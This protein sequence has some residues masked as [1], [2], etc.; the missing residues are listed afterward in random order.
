M[1]PNDL[2]EPSGLTLAGFA[3]PVFDSTAVFRTALAAF[4]APATVLPMPAFSET[5]AGLNR[6]ATAVLLTLLDMDTKLWLSDE[7]DRAQVR[8]Y[9][10]FHTG[11]RFAD[12][13]GQCDF[14][15]CSAAEAAATARVLPVGTPEYPDRGA[16]LIVQVS[17]LTG[18]GESERRTFIGPGIQDRAEL[19]LPGLAPDF[20]TWFAQSKALYPCGVD[21]LFAAS[22]AIA[23]LPRSSICSEDPSCT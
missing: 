7:L 5:P 21:V 23:A 8:D 1:A 10:G 3:E 18:G 4:S 16:T 20:W 6:T 2:S 14:A 13:P 15:L 22:D 11:C 12:A 17:G 19:S 9:F